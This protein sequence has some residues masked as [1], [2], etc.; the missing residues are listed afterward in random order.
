MNKHLIRDEDIYNVHN[1]ETKKG[2]KEMEK[3]LTYFAINNG[4]A[5]FGNE[6]S[7]QLPVH[8]RVYYHLVALE[9]YMRV[10]GIEFE[11]KF[12]MTPKEVRK[13]IDHD[14]HITFYDEKIK[15]PLSQV[16]KYLRYFPVKKDG[17][18]EF[19]ASSPVMTIIQNNKST[20]TIHYGNRRLAVLKPD[21]LD[22][23]VER[24]KLTFKLMEKIKR[25]RLAL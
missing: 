14:I 19:K 16:R 1:T 8:E 24:E 15:L 5:A 4:K 21:F 17:T 22:L 2:D 12:M 3:T 23:D 6:A 9:E 10:M 11:R 25:L 20:Y 18:I 13:V 7:K